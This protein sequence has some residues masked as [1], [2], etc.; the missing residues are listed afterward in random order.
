M[1]DIERGL[2][3]TEHLVLNVQGMTCSGCER[4]LFQA[5][6]S[7][8]SVSNIKT[9]IAL[10]QA[11]FDS[12]GETNSDD[13]IR[14]VEKSTGFACTK[15]KQSAEEMDM[16]VP[17]PQSLANEKS[18]PVGV[19]DIVVIS[20]TTI[21]VSF[22]PKLVGAR[23]LL[24]D[25]LFSLAKLAPP[26]PQ[27]LVTSNRAHFR[28]TALST[29]IAALLTI[30]VLVLAWAPL[31]KHSILYGA[32][33]LGLSTVLQVYSAG[34]FYTAAWKALIFMRM[35]EMD[36]LIVL[37]TTTAYI[38]SI[39]AYACLVVGKPLS[40]GQFFE[41]STLLV[42]LILVGRTVSAFARQKAVESISVESLQANV[43]LL[44]DPKTQK[45]EEIDARLLQYR[46]V[47]K[48][49]PE[50]LIV[51]DGIV[52]AGETEVDES[53][54]TGEATLTTKHPK[55]PVV[56][57]SL[58]HSGTVTVRLTRLPSENTL[59]TIGSMVDEAKLTKPRIQN[60]ADQ[61]ASIFT[62]LILVISLLVFFVWVAVGVAIRHESAKTACVA[63]MTY[64]ISTLVVS[65]PCA[66]GLAVPMVIVIA[67]GVGAKCGLVC[68]TSE[69][70]EIA[71]KISHVVFDK[72]GTLTQGKLFVESEE[73][74]TKEHDI[75]GAILSLASSSKHPVSIAIATHLKP[76][77]NQ[78]CKLD[79]IVTVAGKGIKASWNGRLIRGGNPYW[80]GLDKLPAI[81][82][83]LLLGFTVFCVIVDEEFVAC[84]TLR[85][86][87]RP[88]AVETVRQ[89]RNR[90]IKV[91]IIS[92][93]NEGAVQS[94]AS[95]LD[96]PEHLIRYRCSPE[97][98]QAYIKATLAA[99]KGIVMFC[100]DGTNDAVAL[101]QA[102]IGMHVKGG[103]DI[104][105]S[106]AD[107]VLVRT[108]LNG[109]LALIDLS[110]AFYH[111]VAFNFGWAFTYNTF[112][113]LLAAGAFPNARIPPQYAGLG[114]I[115]SVLPVIVIALQLKWCKF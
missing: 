48:V 31:P 12:N 89:L 92:G 9:S 15:M 67:G 19:E 63:A 113:I 51:T 43:A 71:R 22:M 76:S 1:A 100:G 41:T 101:A 11:E 96:I 5:L 81:Q 115:V 8:S 94:V 93:D 111:R 79:N 108:S 97:E 26:A 40:T 62:P 109:I 52:L 56:A 44:V 106:A 91:S 61:L 112:A 85:D 23:D 98:K 24:S 28:K 2:L 13:L 80:L 14:T 58:N 32:I 86:Q 47:F 99:E 102:N 49:L 75:T 107:V 64:A 27:P 29:L 33:S 30:P 88:G 77:N 82:D 68:Q 74:L 83:T 60:I 38:Y 114:E 70:L 10:A 16:I 55:S 59:K 4:K 39:I 87:L 21:R 66:I 36:L 20:K 46:D 90:S 104:A 95:L 42:T 18:L 54:I 105:K 53:M 3:D 35:I 6:H 69:T 72:T 17:D 50:T 110:R 103:T 25:P 37:S 57:G 65:C 45:E 73:Y 7:F 34:P 84:Y 78:S